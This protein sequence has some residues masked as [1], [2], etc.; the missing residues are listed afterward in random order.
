MSERSLLAT[1]LTCAVA[2]FGSAAAAQEIAPSR[3][4]LVALTE[5][6][7]IES[8]ALSPDGMKV[9]FRVQRPSVGRNTYAIEWYVADLA[10]GKVTVAGDGGEVIYDNGVIEADAPVWAPDS[11]A[12]FRRALVGGAIGIWRTAADGTGSRKVVAG[13]ADVERIAATPEGDALTYWTGPTRAAIEAAERGEYDDGILIDATVDA[14]QGLFRPAYSHGRLATQRL[15]GYW[16][17]R[18]RLLWQ[19]PRTRSRIDLS[20][21]RREPAGQEQARTI[22]RPVESG[23]LEV[24]SATGLVAKASAG[25]EG[26]GPKLE[27]SFGDGRTVACNDRACRTGAIAAL[28]WRPH[29][30]QLLFANQDAYFR[31]TL[32]LFDA[33]SGRTRKVAQGQGLLTGGRDPRSPCAVSAAFAVCVEAGAASPPRLVRIDLETGRRA[34]LLDP[35]R[36]LR[37]RPRPAVDYLLAPT[38]EGRAASTILLTPRQH[39]GRLPLFVMYYH[40][41]GYLRGGMGDEFPFG[42]LVEAKFAVACLTYPPRRAGET[43]VDDYRSAQASVVA[44]IDTLDRRGLIDPKRVGMGGLS[45]GSEVT[46]W[47]AMKTDRIAALATASPQ[48]SPSEYWYRALRGRDAAD[49]YRQRWGAGSPDTDLAPWKLISPELNVDSIKAPLLMQLPEQEYASVMPFY[50]RLSH[51]DTPAEL[52]AFPNESHTKLQPRHRFAAYRRN[53]DWFRYWLQDYRDPDPAQAAQYRRW[54]ELRRR[55]D[56]SAK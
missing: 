41:P 29:H 49:H 52:Y 53:L 34:I 10:T 43:A 36:L 28:A 19:V 6:A 17:S 26:E 31:S 7:D 56:G 32:Y 1:V 24:R 23:L 8:L 37:A 5:V 35:N 55:R 54:D 2:A 42:P 22:P 21:L 27:V 14:R 4:S 33:A 39:R 30:D 47:L 18:D 44:L 13:E 40:C 51:T 9:A 11:R 12:F 3:A 50:A 20:T 48:P 46:M 16:F 45:F 38:G 15:T 25:G